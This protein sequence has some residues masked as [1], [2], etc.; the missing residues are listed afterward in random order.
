MEFSME[1]LDARGL[2]EEIVWFY[3]SMRDVR[4]EKS[5]NFFVFKFGFAFICELTFCYF[6][7]FVTHTHVLITHSSQ[8]IVVHNVFV[9]AICS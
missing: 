6:F 8:H 9:Q 2:R 1:K 4:D 3:I 7:S 5:Q